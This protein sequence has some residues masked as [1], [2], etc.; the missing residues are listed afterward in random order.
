MTQ[1]KL[2]NIPD[3][4]PKDFE[5][6]VNLYLLKHPDIQFVDFHKFDDRTAVLVFEGLTE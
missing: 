4:S 5:E 6:T 3:G 2:F 1:V